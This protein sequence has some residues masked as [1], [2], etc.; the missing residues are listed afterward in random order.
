MT[1]PIDRRA[2]LRLHD[3]RSKAT[4]FTYTFHK[5]TSLTINSGL[6]PFTGPWETKQVAH[7]LRR[8]MFGARNTDIYFL[9][10]MSPS[11]AVDVLLE[12]PPLPDP[13]V[14]DY[15]SEAQDPIVPN[16]FPWVDAPF[17]G[18][19]DEWRERSLK[20][21][22][23]G[24]QLSPEIS[25]Q[26]KM[27]MF[28]HNH[29]PIQFE[30]VDNARYSYR[31]LATLYEHAFGNFKEIVKAL[32]LDPAMLL[33]LNGTLN[34]VNSPDENYA[35]ELQELFCIGKGPDANFTQ[36]DVQ[37]AA[38]VLTGWKTE[39]AYP[40]T[41]FAE[42]AHD[43]DDKQFSEF[44]GNTLIEGKSGPE[45][46]EELDELLDMIFDNEE[47]ARFI[48][49]KLYTFFVYQELTEQVEQD[50]ILPL[51][52]ILR[53]NDWEI[54]PVLDTLLK[55]EHF[56]D[57]WNRGSMLKSPLEQVVGMLREMNVTWPDAS[58]Y[59]ALFQLRQNIL[60]W[61]PDMLQNPGDPPDVSGWPAWFQTPIFYK[62]WITVSTLPRRAQHTDLLL[63]TGYAADTET[64]KIDV[65]SYTESLTDPFDPDALVDEVLAL[66]YGIEVVEVVRQ[67]LKDILIDGQNQDLYWTDAWAD[68]VNN[69][70]NATAFG[71]VETRLQAFFQ[72]IFQLEEY[73]L[74]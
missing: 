48:V 71:V 6:A 55:S 66:F 8:T 37:A 20:C 13:P 26:E 42:N 50:I 41:Y 49:R 51:A 5:P 10:N 57:P 1:K 39:L 30:L 16:G 43:A 14:N 45:G 12:E 28:W 36:E 65:V 62:W 33:Y 53:D 15:G 69:P 61:V 29:I 74:L 38:R 63:F 3:W 23:L 47:T 40:V 31:Y 17:A 22:W 21:W 59:Q 11:A 24:N 35:R 72:A 2:F 7:L 68:Y 54:K 60:S 52:Q 18:G 19:V 46:A 27:V 9:Q 73:Q 58:D 64:V 25:L 44:Y 34:N 4:E 56:F 67:Q 32:T 70:S